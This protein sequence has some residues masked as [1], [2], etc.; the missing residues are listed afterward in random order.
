[1]RLILLAVGRLKDGPERELVGRY[2]ERARAAGRSLGFSGPDLAEC[3]ESRAARPADRKAEEARVLM[4]KAGD[5]ALVVMDEG[6]AM[7]DS[8][9]FATLLAQRRDAGQKALALV[10]GG[11]DGLDPGLVAAAQARIAFGRMTLPHQIVRAL[12]AEQLY[13]AMTILSGHPY[14]RA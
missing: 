9:G 8:A 6:G 11:A 5:A 3:A 12:A 13:R 2:A 7:L 14:H 10:I 1:M 4:E